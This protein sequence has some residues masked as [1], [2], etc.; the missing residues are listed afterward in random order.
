MDY[1]KSVAA[2]TSSRFARYAVSFA[3]DPTKHDIS[4]LQLAT[5][6]NFSLPESWFI[7]FYPSADIRVM[8]AVA[9]CAGAKREHNN[10]ATST[11]ERRQAKHKCTAEMGSAVTGRSLEA[12]AQSHCVLRRSYS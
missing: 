3:G 7:A 2:A 10:R 1:R 8:V 9:A 12:R 11:M 4:N 5:N 6:V